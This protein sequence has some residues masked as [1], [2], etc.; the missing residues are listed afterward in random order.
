[1][2]FFWNI[3]LV[4][5]LRSHQPLLT[6]VMNEWQVGFFSRACSFGRWDLLVLSYYTQMSCSMHSCIFNT[7]WRRRHR[8]PRG[9]IK[10]SVWWQPEIQRNSQAVGESQAVSSPA[11]IGSI[12]KPT[13]SGT[14]QDRCNNKWNWATIK[15]STF[16]F[17]PRYR[18]YILYCKHYYYIH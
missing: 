13:C 16:H 4:L 11:V 14:S 15:M 18:M 3:F 9:R 17:M 1:M 6:S 5:L 12:S 8:Y 7:D 2:N 10:V